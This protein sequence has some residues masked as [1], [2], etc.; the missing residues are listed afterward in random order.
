MA[1]SCAVPD[2]VPR[3]YFFAAVFGAASEAPGDAAGAEEEE[4][5][6]FESTATERF[7]LASV[8]E[9]EAIRV[10][11]AGDSRAAD[12]LRDRDPRTYSRAD[13]SSNRC[14]ETMSDH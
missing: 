6:A 5:E 12:V 3:V 1:G 11:I 4:G 7:G 10:G 9:A 13:M 2:N 14:G 8:V